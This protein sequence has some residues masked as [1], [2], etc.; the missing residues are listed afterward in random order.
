[1]Q[2]MQSVTECVFVLLAYSSNINFTQRV[3]TSARLQINHHFVSNDVLKPMV[4]LD[5]FAYIS[6]RCRLVCCLG[7]IVSAQH[8]LIEDQLC[9]PIAI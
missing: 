8:S 5:T 1:M 4:L 6:G 2:T 7:L 3:G 9:V